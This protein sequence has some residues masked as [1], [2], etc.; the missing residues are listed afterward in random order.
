M[1]VMRTA[2]LLAGLT[3]LFLAVGYA[4]GV[5][6]GVGSLANLTPLADI[7][8]DTI[9]TLQESF[10]LKQYTETQQPEAD[11]GLAGWNPDPAYG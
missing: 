2:I 11:E 5:L 9:D 4:I 10:I 3:A 8:I 1:N 6:S 7:L